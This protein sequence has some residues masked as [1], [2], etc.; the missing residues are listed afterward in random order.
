LPLLVFDDFD[1]LS[2]EQIQGFQQAM[3]SGE[4]L[5]AAAV[6]LARQSALAPLDARALRFFEEGLSVNFRLQEVGPDESIVYLHHRL[7]YLQQ[8]S[9]TTRLPPGIF[10][11]LLAS[12]IVIAASIGAF[13]L[14]RGIV[15]GVSAPTRATR[16]LLVTTEASTPQPAMDEVMRA[17]SAQSTPISEPAPIAATALPDFAPEPHERAPNT[18]PPGAGSGRPPPSTISRLS[19]A[20]IAALLARGDKFL[21][22]GDIA[23]ARLYYERAADAGDAM[24][25]I[26]LATT[27]DSAFLKQAG[28]RGHLGD[29]AQA[30]SWYRRAR[31]LGTAG[32]GLGASK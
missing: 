25:A 29:A 6:L 7:A 20:E 14:A 1:L 27:F 10:H 24:A 11:A 15:E 13:L 18:T 30:L 32:A 23:S 5:N 9:S 31:D 28:F 22:I 19:A 12:G 4:G 17:A 21:G 3:L 26:R 16:D 8:H 2:E